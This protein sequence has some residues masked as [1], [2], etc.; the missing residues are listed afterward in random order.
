[1]IDISNY[2]QIII[3]I[4]VVVN[5]ITFSYIYVLSQ[6]DLIKWEDKFNNIILMILNLMSGY[7]GIVVST[8]MYNY[9]TESKFIKVAIPLTFVLE[10]LII[11]IVLGWDYIPSLIQKVQ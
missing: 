10:I 11:A 7:V 8:R 4:V 9:R 1:M 2:I 3:G 6:T 5:L